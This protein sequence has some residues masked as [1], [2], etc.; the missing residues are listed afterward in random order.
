MRTPASYGVAGSFVVDTTR[1]GGA[2]GAVTAGIGSSSTG[3]MAHR[4]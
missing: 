3:H 4:T 1:I 2:S